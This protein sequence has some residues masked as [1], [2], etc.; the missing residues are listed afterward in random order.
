MCYLKTDCLFTNCSHWHDRQ[1]HTS[2]QHIPISKLSDGSSHFWDLANLQERQPSPH[3]LLPSPVPRDGKDSPAAANTPGRC[4]QLTGA[5]F[6]PIPHL[7]TT[8]VQIRPWVFIYYAQ[9]R[10]QWEPVFPC[11]G[12]ACSFNEEDSSLRRCCQLLKKNAAL[13]KGGNPP[14]K[15]WGTQPGETGSCSSSALTTI[16]LKGCEGHRVRIV[17][18][19]NGKQY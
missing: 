11:Q 2:C 12:R 15:C 16:I 18:V 10:G 7:P 14:W 17:S 4:L 8:A 19:L 3:V 9:S 1:T 5:K 13:F 6:V